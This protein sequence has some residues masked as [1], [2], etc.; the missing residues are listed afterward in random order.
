MAHRSPS[1]RVS[2]DRRRASAG[3][4]RRRPAAARQRPRRRGTAGPSSLPP[5]AVQRD[6]AERGSRSR[7]R[8]A[9]SRSNNGARAIVV[10]GRAQLE[11]FGLGDDGKGVG[12][13][14]VSRGRGGRRD[15]RPDGRLAMSPQVLAAA[16]AASRLVPSSSRS[17]RALP[18]R[19]I[20][21]EELRSDPRRR[22]PPRARAKSVRRMV[23][24]AAMPSSTAT[25]L[26]ARR[27][28]GADL[29]GQHQERQRGRGFASLRSRR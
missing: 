1:R 24:Q 2:R 10:G 18:H 12:Q 3:V 7:W 22:A 28:F 4:A 14:I 15:G 5:V 23:R 9:P 25:H 8:S 16:R 11:A 13:G 6:L 17:W 29:I 20:A 27:D 26:A 19:R 21:G